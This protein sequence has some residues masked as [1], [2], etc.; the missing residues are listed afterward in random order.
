MPGDQIK[1]AE[2]G[3]SPAISEQK[4][5][6][7]I[8][9]A[10]KPQEKLVLDSTRRF[11]PGGM[12]AGTSGQQGE[13]TRPQKTTE[14]QSKRH[15]GHQSWLYEKQVKEVEMARSLGA[16]QREWVILNKAVNDSN[17]YLIEKQWRERE[18]S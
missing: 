18:K 9:S 7:F 6:D 4:S 16:S 15:Q 11:L 13:T 14:Q 1:H 12:D 3:K 5:R 2:K 8:K 17:K 10:T